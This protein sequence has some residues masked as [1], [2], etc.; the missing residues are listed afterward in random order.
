M[1]I[2]ASS[3][4]AAVTAVGVAEGL[5]VT[6][7]AGLRS[8]LTIGD[9]PHLFVA[10]PEGVPIVVSVLGEYGL[11]TEE[12]QLSLHL[13]THE[14]TQAEILARADSL[15]AALYS[16]A[17]LAGLLDWVYVS[18]IELQESPTDDA[19]SA[20]LGIIGQATER[21][22]R[23]TVSATLELPP[24]SSPGDLLGELATALETLT[25]ATRLASDYRQDL[26]PVAL[27]AT[28]YQLRGA[29]AGIAATS[30]NVER[31]L[32]AVEVDLVHVLDGAERAWTEGALQTALL[33]L[34]D[35]TWWRAL[36]HV[37]HVEEIA[38]EVAG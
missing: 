25:S 20:S 29:P 35:L 33:S 23:A 12:V 24:A 17:T 38:H 10:Q 28:V 32:L 3:V 26:E 15:R 8:G 2:A 9:F 1:T 13:H 6:P 22:I 30:S 19:R 7:S 4:V 31:T 5:V 36:T 18:E 37:Y 11:R 34:V 16:D 21:E 27:G 14:E